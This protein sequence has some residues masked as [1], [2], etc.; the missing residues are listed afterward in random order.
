MVNMVVGANKEGYHI[1]NVNLESSNL[2]SSARKFKDGNLSAADLI[3]GSAMGKKIL[4]QSIPEEETKNTYSMA[5]IEEF[6]DSSNSDTKSYA[7]APASLSS[8]VA[9]SLGKMGR[10]KSS[11]S[12][13]PYSGNPF[14]NK[15]VRCGYNID[16]NS[17]FF[18]VSDEEGKSSLVGKINNTVTVLKDF[19]APV[20]YKLQ[21]RKDSQNV[22][23]VRVGAERYMVEITGEKMGVLIEL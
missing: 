20:K 22:Y 16:N 2:Y 4:K 7:T 23:I 15:V 12:D 17:G 13:M 14:G 19:N 6:F 18:I 9:E 21:I 11:K 8:R 5:T 1:K 10:N 3:S